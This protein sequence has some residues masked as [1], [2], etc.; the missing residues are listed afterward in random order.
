MDL[1]IRGWL[2]EAKRCI[3]ALDAE[4]IAVCNFAP[5]GRD[6]SWLVAHGERK[7]GKVYHG[8]IK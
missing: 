2:D 4:L 6:R 7:L 1:T 3:A 5:N 8:R